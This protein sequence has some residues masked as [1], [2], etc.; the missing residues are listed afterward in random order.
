[1]ST[2]RLSSITGN[3]STPEVYDYG[4][5]VCLMT[6][7]ETARYG[8]LDRLVDLEIGLFRE[9]AGRHERFAD[10]T[11]PERE[12]RQDFERLLVTPSA[13]VLVARA[14]T[15]VVGHAVGYLGQLS[16]TRLPYTFG[17]LRSM[18][19]DVGYRDSGIGGL[20]AESFISWARAQGCAEVHVDSY[21]AN[22]GAQRSTSA[23]DSSPRASPECSASTRPDVRQPSLRQVRVGDYGHR[24]EL[25]ER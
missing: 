21:A 17:V 6:I 10:L 3:G 13:L 11:W 18:Y 16:P 7:V 5:T 25:A 4:S 20:L 24:V 14:G 1:M 9:D 12:G 2:P 19:V 8:D 23:M 15:A 22:E